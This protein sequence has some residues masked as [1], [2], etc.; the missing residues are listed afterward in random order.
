MKIICIGR[1]F[2]NHAK[3]LGNKIPTEPLFFLKPETALQPKNHPF[4]IPDFSNNIQY[5]IELVLKINKTGKHIEEKFAH[6]YY[7]E[8]GLGIDFTARDIQNQCKKNGL[9]W[10]KAKGFDGSAQISNNFIKISDLNIH[11]IPFSLKKNN[12]Q[13]QSGNSKEMIFSFNTIISY[14]SKFY[15]LKIGDL[16]YTGTPSGVGSIK[17]GDRLE[18]YIKNQKMFNVIVK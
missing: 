9:P 16:I 18:G 10:E 8:I 3:E 17:K 5:E 2:P 6:K 11:N 13:V 4:F 12:K 7:S 14:V 15:T 1:N